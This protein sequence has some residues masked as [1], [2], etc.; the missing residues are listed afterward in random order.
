MNY[1]D[2]STLEDAEKFSDIINKQ[3][4][5]YEKLVDRLIDIV[6]YE[7]WLVTNKHHN[8]EDGYIIGNPF[9]V[10]YY[11]EREEPF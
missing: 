6:E 8:I 10:R 7:E 3:L 5:E 1:E 2:F 4:N 9:I 11:P